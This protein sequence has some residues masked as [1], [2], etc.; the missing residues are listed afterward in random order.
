MAQLKL[1]EETSTEGSPVITSPAKTE[2]TAL[3]EKSPEDAYTYPT[4]AFPAQRPPP[5]NSPIYSSPAK[6]SPVHF[7]SLDPM[8]VST[9]VAI[10]LWMDANTCQ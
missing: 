3:R 10:L 4:A 8:N 6:D 9:G 5:N 2:S 7:T 1:Q